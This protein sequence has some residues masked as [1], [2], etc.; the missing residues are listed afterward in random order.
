MNNSLKEGE[1]V[2]DKILEVKIYTII[3]LNFRGTAAHLPVT[4][5]GLGIGVRSMVIAC[6]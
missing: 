4:G 1:I 5:C 3:I 2:K 6:R